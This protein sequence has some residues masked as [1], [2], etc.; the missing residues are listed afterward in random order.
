MTPLQLNL[1]RQVVLLASRR[2]PQKSM[3]YVSI[4]N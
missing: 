1:K 4:L 3:S 2:E